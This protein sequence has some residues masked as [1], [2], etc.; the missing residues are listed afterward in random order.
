MSESSIELHW[1]RSAPNLHSARHAKTHT[2]RYND[3]CELQFDAAEMDK[4]KQRAHR[5]RFI[6]NSLTDSVRISIVNVSEP[7]EEHARQR[8]NNEWK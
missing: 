2:V 7:N 5:F 3:D 8:Q 6:A 1:L 4:M